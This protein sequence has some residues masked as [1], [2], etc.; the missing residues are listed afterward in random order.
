V[1]PKALLHR[2]WTDFVEHGT[3]RNEVL[4]DKIFD[5][6]RDSAVRLA[7]ATMVA[8]HTESRPEDILEEFLDPSQFEPFCDWMIEGDGH[9]RIS[10]YGLKPLSNAVALAF[11]AKSLEAKLK[12][13]D[14]AIHV[15]HM[16]GDLSRLFIEGGR[17]TLMAVPELELQADEETLS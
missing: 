14:Q 4:L 2:V 5:S 15:A 3:V 12:Y 6:I 7:I 13:L 11:E 8:G 10:D 9:W 16:R 1:V 17:D